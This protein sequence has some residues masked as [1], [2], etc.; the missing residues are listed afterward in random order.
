MYLNSTLP[1]LLGASFY[2]APQTETMEAVISVFHE[3]TDLFPWQDSERLENLVSELATFSLTDLKYDYSILFEGQGTMPAP[4]WGSYYL[5]IDQLLM[6]ETTMAFREFLH[7]NNIQLATQNKEP[8]DQFGLML[9]ALSMLLDKQD[10]E[11]VDKLLNEFLL[12]W[13]FQYLKLIQDASLEHQFYPILAKITEMYLREMPQIINY[14]A[15]D[16]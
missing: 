3:L 5:E 8:E 16:N 14:L 15:D 1:K 4:P 2:H 10:I 7:A 13:A 11:N 12:P 9:M 6:G